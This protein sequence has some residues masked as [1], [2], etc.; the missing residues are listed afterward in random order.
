MSSSSKQ[1]THHPNLRQEVTTTGRSSTNAITTTSHTLKLYVD[2]IPISFEHRHIDIFFSLIS[3]F[4]RDTFPLRAILHAT[5]PQHCIVLEHDVKAARTLLHMRLN[6]D[7]AVQCW[8]QRASSGASEF[9]S[10]SSRLHKRRRNSRYAYGRAT[11]YD[12]VQ[13]STTSL[14]IGDEV[15]VVGCREGQA[16]LYNGQWGRITAHRTK[17]PWY[18]VYFRDGATVP[19]RSH[20]LK[21]SEI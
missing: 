14:N 2:L 21:H 13:K 16:K 11:P 8:T 15:C 3:S 4:F 12:T 5:K 7:L 1:P 6:D 20:C 19:V 17:S 18:T 10:S 9:G